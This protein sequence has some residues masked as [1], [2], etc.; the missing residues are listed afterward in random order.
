VWDP[1]AIVCRKDGAP[2]P[3][4]K[5]SSLLGMGLDPQRRQYS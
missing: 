4:K 1:D 3:Q 5:D 2:Q